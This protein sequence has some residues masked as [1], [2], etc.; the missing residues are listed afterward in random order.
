MLNRVARTGGGGRY[1]I[2]H[3]AS[4]AYMHTRPVLSVIGSGIPQDAL[5]HHSHVHVHVHV[6]AS[7]HV[8]MYKS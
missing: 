3:M 6:G 8:H 4:L 7:D 1:K 2:M 5:P